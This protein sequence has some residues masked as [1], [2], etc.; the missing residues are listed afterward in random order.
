MQTVKYALLYLSPSNQFGH[1]SKFPAA[2]GVE[3]GCLCLYSLFLSDLCLHLQNNPPLM[4]L[5]LS[6]PQKKNKTS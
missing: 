1:F 2:S 4:A 5:K 6:Q 3:A